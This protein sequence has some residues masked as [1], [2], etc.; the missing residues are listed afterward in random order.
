MRRKVIKEF[1]NSFCQRILDLPDGYDLA[2]FAR[3]GTGTY[4][5][6]I[7]TGDCSHNGNSI[8]S[9][10]LCEIYQKWMDQQLEKH[11]I[12]RAGILEAIVRIQIE[13]KDVSLR[14]SFGHRFASAHF[15][16]RCQSEIKTDEK[17]YVGQMHGDK[18]WGF[19]WFYEQQ[20]GALPDVWP[21]T[22]N[23][24]P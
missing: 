9:L 23:Q 19:D 17:S 5:A 11:R 20:Y 4:K 16:F 18:E 12:E 21:P 10:R 22:A 14:S 7:L 24:T 1:V 13:V 6:N 15:F 3:Y 8:P 2:C